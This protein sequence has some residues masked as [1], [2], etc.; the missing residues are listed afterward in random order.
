[1]NTVTI[2][3]TG[4]IGASFGLALKQAGFKG[5]ILGVS[6][7][8]ALRDALQC[9]AIDAAPPAED[10]VRAAD[11]VYL[12]QE[13]HRIVETLDR[14]GHCV[15]PGA[16]VTDAGSTK[17]QIVARAQQA[18][19]SG[20]FLG[21]H[22]LAGKEKRGAAAAEASLFAGRPYILTP[23]D[24]A[25]LETPAAR[26]FLGWVRAIG[27][28]PIIL[29]PN[30]HDQIVAFTSHLPQLL[31]TTLASTLAATVGEQKSNI[32]GPGLDDTVRLAGSSYEIWRDI[33]ETNRPAIEAALDAF[34]SRLKSLRA[35]LG[36]DKVRQE[37][38]IANEFQ[39]RRRT[40]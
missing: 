19:A 21:G 2:I 9:G 25:E 26:E 27:A 16:L 31:S 40:V 36:S 33:I 13:I 18:L 38:E 23:A 34:E 32:S 10:A 4:L 17:A 15:A 30:D 39:R 1:M 35:D 29:T 8:P 6:S 37:F 3:G 12:S 11:V 28:V 20:Q 5:R 14:I 22:P 7:P 24:P